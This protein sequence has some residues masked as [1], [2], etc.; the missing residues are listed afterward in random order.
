MALML[1]FFGIQGIL[2]GEV[3]AFTGRDGSMPSATFASPLV[4]WIGLV[5]VLVGLYVLIFFVWKKK[6]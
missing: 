2:T 1:V 6:K 4:P 5:L 3:P